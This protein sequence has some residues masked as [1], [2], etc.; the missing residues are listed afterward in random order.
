MGEALTVTSF[1]EA[2]ELF[3]DAVWAGVLAGGL[4]GALGVYVVLRRMVFLSAALSQAAGLGVTLAFYA[5]I[6]LGVGAALASPSLGALL[7]TL[8]AVGVLARRAEG[9]AG[10]EGALGAV[11]L[12]GS[13]GTLLV[14]TRIVQELQDVS[15]LLFGTAV[16]VLPEDLRELAVT[17]AVVGALHVWWWRGFAAVTLD[18]EGARVRGLPTRALEGA[19]LVTLALGISVS[20]RVL[21]ALPT[22]AFSVLPAL[23]AATWAP[24]LPRA[25]WLGAALGA[26]CGFGGYVLSYLY[27]LPVGA[28][29]AA[30]GAALFVGSAAL[31]GLQGALRWRP[32][33]R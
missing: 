19:L 10:R 22:F 2:W 4:L 18:A 32:A 33:R 17:A 24:N 11:F 23:V 21:G 15:A 27:E 25:L 31:R 30:L 3:A 9:G 26:G 12:V 29:Q 8:F 16:A 13:A 28:T 7:A 14:G 5:Q 1:F 6:H 20:T